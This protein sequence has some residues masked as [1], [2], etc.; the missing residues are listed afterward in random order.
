[1]ECLEADELTLLKRTYAAIF[2]GVNETSVTPHFEMVSSVRFA[3]ELYGSLNS[4]SERSCF[5]MARWCTLDG[6]ID[7]SGRDLRPGIILYYVR[8]NIEIEGNRAT[9]ILAAVKW[10]SKHPQQEKLG[11]PAEVWCR[12]QF[13]PEGGASFIPIQRILSKFVPAY[14]VIDRERVLVVCTIP[15]KVHC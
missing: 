7:T 11:A 1:M 8:Q 2:N 15:Q 3:G 4:R 6:N 12:N 14:E 5:V 10:F 13:E 9:C